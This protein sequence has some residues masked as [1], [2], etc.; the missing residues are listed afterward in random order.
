MPSPVGAGAA[1]LREREKK[2]CPNHIQ[3]ALTYTIPRALSS[4]QKYSELENPFWKQQRK[5]RVEW[6]PIGTH[7][8][9]KITATSVYYY[10]LLEINGT[11][12][13]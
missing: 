10:S 12:E 11:F 3:A 9:G 2:T 6:P 8:W 1:L 4:P 13:Q 5:L 7:E